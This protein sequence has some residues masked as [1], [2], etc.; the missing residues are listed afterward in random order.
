MAFRKIRV[1]IETA[2]LRISGVLQLPTE[3]F[4]SR[5]TDFLN[6]HE[7]GFIALTDAEVVPFDGSPAESRDYVAVG[8][9]HIVALVETGDLG[10]VDDDSA[11]ASLADYSSPSTPPPPPPA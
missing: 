8:T 1:Q 10:T 2:Q 3:G 5:V 4:R 11:G 6:G 9:R 7:S